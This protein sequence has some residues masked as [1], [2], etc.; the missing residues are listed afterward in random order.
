MSLLN[1]QKKKDHKA[2]L[3]ALKQLREEWTTTSSNG[4]MMLHSLSRDEMADIIKSLLKFIHRSDAVAGVEEGTGELR[5]LVECAL[6][7][8]QRDKLIFCA[9]EVFSFCLHHLD[10][11]DHLSILA[12]MLQYECYR[13]RLKERVFMKLMEQVVYHQLPELLQKVREKP[14][15]KQRVLVC[16]KVL[17]GLVQTSPY[18]YSKEGLPLVKFGVLFES[19]Y[20][21]F[22]SYDV[23][24]TVSL[25]LLIVYYADDGI[26]EFDE[27]CLRLF[28]EL[29]LKPFNSFTQDYDVW[30]LILIR[31]LFKKCSRSKD[32]QGNL[33]ATL[34]N[35]WKCIKVLLPDFTNGDGNSA[36]LTELVKLF[37]DY[38]KSSFSFQVS[39]KLLRCFHLHKFAADLYDMMDTEQIVEENLKYP[40]VLA[41]SSKA[42]IQQLKSIPN[43]Y[44]CCF[45]L[46]KVLKCF[47]DYDAEQLVSLKKL[48]ERLSRRIS[49]HEMFED[50]VIN[51]INSPLL[52]SG[53][54]VN[55]STCYHLYNEDL[56]LPASI[57]IKLLTLNSNRLL[58]REEKWI[59]LIKDNFIDLSIQELIEYGSIP[60]IDDNDLI[61]NPKTKLNEMCYWDLL[62]N[63]GTDKLDKPVVDREYWNQDLCTT[64]ILTELT[65]AQSC[66]SVKFAFFSLAMF[67]ILDK[68]HRV[69]SKEVI[70]DCIDE[71][72]S[73]LEKHWKFQV[74]EDFLLGTRI[75]RACLLKVGER[76]VNLAMK[77]IY[78]SIDHARTQDDT[79]EHD[80][81]V[82][83]HSEVLSEDTSALTRIR[84]E[85]LGILLSFCEDNNPTE[86]IKETIIAHLFSLE[87]VG[88]HLGYYLIK[89][90][91]VR[92]ILKADETAFKDFVHTLKPSMNEGS[93][94]NHFLYKLA[95]N[96]V[97]L[98][99]GDIVKAL[100]VPHDILAELLSLDT[101]SFTEHIVKS[102][103]SYMLL[104]NFESFSLK[105][106]S[107]WYKLLV[108]NAKSDKI[109]ETHLISQSKNVEIA[110]SIKRKK[111]DFESM[112]Y[113]ISLNVFYNLNDH[114]QVVAIKKNLSNKS[115]L[116]RIVIPVLLRKKKFQMI[117]N[118]KKEFSFDYISPAILLRNSSLASSQEVEE[119]IKFMED[120]GIQ[121]NALQNACN[122]IINCFKITKITEE[123]M[124][125]ALKDNTISQS[126]LD[127]FRKNQ[128]FDQNYDRRFESYAFD[129]DVT[130][131]SCKSI[132]EQANFAS[133]DEL[134]KSYSNS[135][136]LISE[137]LVKSVPRSI[138]CLISILFIKRSKKFDI[139]IL[140][141][142]RLLLLE[143]G[144]LSCSLLKVCG[145][146]KSMIQMLLDLVGKVDKLFVE[147]L[148]RLVYSTR[149]IVDLAFLNPLPSDEN[150]YGTSFNRLA[151]YVNSKYSARDCIKALK[152]RVSNEILLL[153]SLDVLLDLDI[154]G[155]KPDEKE[156]LESCL[157]SI[158]ERSHY[159]AQLRW[160]AFRLYSNMR[161]FSSRKDSS[162][163]S[164]SKSPD[165]LLL[166]SF[167]TLEGVLLNSIKE[168]SSTSCSKLIH[169]IVHFLTELPNLN[170][171]RANQELFNL[172]LDKRTYL[173]H[174]LV[175]PALF[176]TTKTTS[177]D[178]SS[179][180]NSDFVYDL[181]S[182]VFAEKNNNSMMSGLIDVVKAMYEE[183]DLYWDF[184][185]LLLCNGVLIALS[186][187]KNFEKKLCALLNDYISS[188]IYPRLLLEIILHVFSQAIILSKS[189]RYICPLPSLDLGKVCEIAKDAD[190]F[191][192]SAY[193]SDV[194]LAMG[195]AIKFDLNSVYNG[196]SKKVDSDL[197]Y[198]TKEE[199]LSVPQLLQKLQHENK[200]RSVSQFSSAFNLKEAY[201]Q[202]CVMQDFIVEKS[203]HKNDVGDL[204]FAN[205]LKLTSWDFSE[206]ELLQIENPFEATS[207]N[208]YLCLNILNRACNNYKETPMILDIFHKEGFSRENSMSCL[209]LSE[210][211]KGDSKMISE[212]F[213]LKGRSNSL[214]VKAIYA[215]LWLSISRGCP[216]GDRSLSNDYSKN[217]LLNGISYCRKNGLLQEATNLFSKLDQLDV[218]RD[219][220]NS[221]KYELAKIVW[222]SGEKF[223]A[224][225]MLSKLH[226]NLLSCKKR[227]SAELDLIDED[228]DYTSHV[229]NSKLL[230]KLGCWN[231]LLKA[232]K[233]KIILKEYFR[234][235]LELLIHNEPMVTKKR[236]LHLNRMA[237]FCLDSFRELDK[238]ERI[239]VLNST[240][241]RSTEEI[242]NIDRRIK[243][244][245]S[246]EKDKLSLQRNKLAIQ[247]NADFNELNDLEKD[248]L[249]FLATFFDS[250]IEC[251]TIDPTEK[252]NNHVY[253]LISIWFESHHLDELN[254]RLAK[255]MMKIPSYKFLSLI[256][257]LVSRL[258]VVEDANGNPFNNL[259]YNLICRA[260][261]DH[262]YHCLF[263]LFALKNNQSGNS[264]AIAKIMLDNLSKNSSDDRKTLLAEFEAAVVSL[265]ELAFYN[266][267]NDTKSGYK[268]KRMSTI[269]APQRLLYLGLLDSP[270]PVPT[271]NVAVKKDAKYNEDEL[272]KIAKYDD[273]FQLVGG[274]NL[275]KK[276]ICV[277]SNGIRYSQLV[278]GKD[279]LRQDCILEQVFS[280]MND[281]FKKHVDAEKR[282]LKM[283]TFAV[284]PLSSRSGVLEWVDGHIPLGDWLIA[285][286]EHYHPQ[287]LKPVECREM[288]SSEFE[289][290]RAGKNKSFSDG[291][292]SVYKSI[293]QRFNPVMKMFF[294]EN[295]Y[296]PEKWFKS[297]LKFT[298]SNAVA[299]MLGY[300]LGIGDRH[301]FNILIS[302]HDADVLHIDLGIAFDAGKLLMCPETVPF[303]LTRDIVDG[304]VSS[305]VEGPFR[306]SCEATLKVIREEKNIL[307]TVLEVLKF[308]PLYT[309]TVLD[310]NTPSESKS[311]EN[312]QNNIRDRFDQEDINKQAERALSAV[313]SR[314]DESLSIECHVNELITMASSEENLAL[315]Y[316]GWQAWM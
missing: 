264:G 228:H 53:A 89:S 223:F 27:C 241:Q 315:M 110:H 167:K 71:A 133:F 122:L 37:Y 202:S 305:T 70:Q 78:E 112:D 243:L 263:H 64:L 38:H 310:T 312:S 240:V 137:L 231:W 42:N 103:P 51:L 55:T 148:S 97:I 127:L 222:Q 242:K 145:F 301:S 274:I 150:L 134:L 6:R 246:S 35:W 276:V 297:K 195:H 184:I 94:K 13:L 114:E 91:T 229:F 234:P 209:L 261:T 39:G 30:Y 117:T 194:S 151:S 24:I 77:I 80:L 236:A 170:L 129:I 20:K 308:D 118:L 22:S 158:F 1:S 304:M 299:S 9:H 67:F 12:L 102:L 225:D 174:F 218:L 283:K 164:A 75:I 250:V 90:E 215:D 44:T 2:A 279:D 66:T 5:L 198:V 175:D 287:D 115:I 124:F 200:W 288:M 96:M 3:D 214:A 256:Y 18:L 43:D 125:Q 230:S 79:R 313:K 273:S 156:D 265:N 139:S 192:L 23:Y 161:A 221:K 193:I 213:R 168:G 302:T 105:N 113:M 260:A 272:I 314:L 138:I 237:D 254:K 159:S 208:G 101:D 46:L 149:E 154:S 152:F 63:E 95:C 111:Y 135:F 123:G 17:Y 171:S 226:Q 16:A 121:S 257:Q 294:F 14:Q 33:K 132:V 86:A 32:K 307:L 45:G 147:E 206:N 144:S 258:A 303:R 219:Q 10:N 120:K 277:G 300:L 244:A 19:I 59:K 36:L 57:K 165:E 131:R 220:P 68:C 81:V 172:I 178:V 100:E 270:V 104:K 238:S 255:R 203:S 163:S 54:Y 99:S 259:L 85:L 47:S 160:K 296:D 282:S 83:P 268:S 187:S 82:F 52:W 249:T 155:L 72:F 291:R 26:A 65:R 269:K 186:H 188:G 224:I 177:N 309:W 247:L 162:K 76:C 286:H 293:A 252:F 28:D 136:V 253:K 311:R 40:L 235:S 251:L 207:L 196:L 50:F 60:F 7:E 87:D 11:E 25:C 88:Y 166:D 58:N 108:D 233:P 31:L 146:H 189:D 180:T 285:A 266:V 289:K 8:S 157:S 216:N 201:F 142:Y 212:R 275:P 204:E 143:E 92:N 267:K 190:M 73:F 29:S 4:S 116:H 15:N 119:M 107:T 48:F 306:R 84:I 130:L 106:P 69:S 181:I 141:L 140:V 316:H 61:V 271:V 245:S 169:N 179:S 182:L 49:E 93:D 211:K 278:K 232:Q 227:K 290:V 74:S 284:V 109:I 191:Q 210:I 295:F 126:E 34:Q 183:Q 153:S 248:K 262:P 197:F 292:L 98:D 128:A 41:L 199:N 173:G 185:K 176:E 21:D 217:I 281:L 56:Y 239:S 62:I 205:M 298:R 280:L